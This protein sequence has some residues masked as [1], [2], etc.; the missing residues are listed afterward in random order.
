MEDNNARNNTKVLVACEYS[1]IVRDAFRKQ[2]FDAISCDL[3]ET[4]KNSEH[5]IQGDIL[6]LLEKRSHEF[7]LM[8]AH[9][10]CTYLA[11]SGS[12]W[13]YEKEGRW[14]DMI[15][16]ATFFRKLYNAD[17]PHIA[18]EN[19]VMHK[20]GRKIIGAG[21]PDQTFQPYHFGDMESKRICIWKKNLPDLKY[22]DNREEEAMKMDEKE[23]QKKHWLGSGNSK[24]RSRFFPKV[25]KAMA[26]QWGDYIT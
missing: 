18:V 15:D 10:P 6:E 14:K 23:L 25:A 12:R 2:G 19:P 1:G 26:K 9:P 17:I 8:I 11:N 7:D 13:L 24:E 20:Y 3:R 16:G 22:T 5:H 21:K 4:E